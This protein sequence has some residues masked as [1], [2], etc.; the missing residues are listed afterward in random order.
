MDLGKEQRERIFDPMNLT[1]GTER[2]EGI[3]GVQRLRFGFVGRRKERA[4]ALRRWRGG[5]RRFVVLGLG[6]LGKTTL[7]A[8]LAPLL[9]RDLKPGGARVLAL[10]GRH[11]GAQP[12]PILALWQEFQAARS[13]EA[14]SQTLA[15]LQEEG[16]TGEALGK[17]ALALTKLEGGLLLYLDDAES[18]QVPLGEGEI[19]RFR[20]PELRAFWDV[21][22]AG[23]ATARTLG[24]LA[25]SRYLPEGTP[26]EAELH[27]PQLRPYEVVR[28]LAWMPTLG[29]LP[30]EDRAWLAEKIDGHPRTIEYLEVLARAQEKKRARPGGRYEGTKWREEILE[31]VL[32]KTQAKVDADLLLGKV[33]E[34]LPEDAQEHLGRCTVIT[35][36]APWDAV[37]A[38]ETTEGTAARLAETGMLSPFQS[39]IGSEDWWAPH[40]L[41]SE[42]A[43]KRWRGEPR[44]AHHKIGE[45]YE[46]KWKDEKLQVWAK[47]AV[48]HLTDARD[49]DAAWP[50]AQS[51][52]I[53]LRN[54][55]RYREALAW[56]DRVLTAAPTGIQLGKTLALQIQIGSD[57]NVLPA[58]AEKLLLQAL[59]LV[60]PEDQSFVL[61]ELG[62]LAQR[63]GELRK[64]ADYLGRSVQVETAL[65]GENH[66]DVAAS[67]H[68]L[69][70]VLQAQGDL[71]GA[72]RNLGRSLQIS[73]QVFGTEIHPDV[74]ASLHA[75]AGVLQDQGDL[76]G[77][78]RN[79]ERSLQ[80]K[81]Q[82]FGTEIHP[83]VATSLHALAGV[84]QDQGDLDGAKRNLER[85]LRIKAQVFGTEI[86]P[87]VATSLHSLAMVLQA[88]G[89]LD[90]ARK[91]LEK[92]LE[93]EA[94][95]YG[96][97][98]HYST[99]ITEM[100]LG[101]LLL[102][103]GE[104]EAGAKLLAHAYSVCLKQLG[105]EHPR[106]RRLAKLFEKE[107][108]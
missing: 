39:P 56:I 62:K 63:K 105:P 41:V 49:G 18:L 37:L 73:A 6:G 58:D 26:Q 87:S 50:A 106:T 67:L 96:S 66:V 57:A 10:D 71:D 65:K 101:F 47:R 22:L 108:S 25:S 31:P 89:D 81:A 91:N 19:G 54:A 28:L 32:S 79:L 17:A 48:Q 52:V 2:V 11:A 90:G 72:K 20:N 68:T 13:D 34:A 27:L 5:E 77:A 29:R 4:E 12:D 70:G 42:E 69:A 7:C 53:R 55:G 107:A 21:L 1:G 99:A 84:L 92:V 59:E 61:D 15:G 76:D 104:T 51:I 36:P 102:Q 88:Q 74:A 75:L 94:V 83:S 40:R 23:T 98:E 3:R 80:I 16:L 35:A 43:Q 100:S 86:H 8:E 103:T 9:A 95:V 14:W 93:I 38:L 97:R 85:S 78:K 46:Q 30:A 33:W 45:W 64:A 24:L 60:G 82:V 44:K